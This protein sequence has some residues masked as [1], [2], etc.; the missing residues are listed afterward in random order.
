[1]IIANLLR[2]DHPSGVVR[3]STLPF[4][5]TDPEG[6]T[7]IGGG[8]ILAL[9]PRGASDAQDGGSVSITWNGASAA[10][11]AEAFHPALIRSRLWIAAVW[12]NEGSPPTRAHG[13]V[14]AWTG[15]VETPQIGG[16][17]S[18]PSISITAQSYLLDMARPKRAL[19]T[20]VSQK[21]ID[22]DDTGADWIAQL[23]DYSPKLSARQ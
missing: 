1:M 5:W 10:L 14:N 3:M 17:P 4:D 9:S 19:L 11:I 6:A 20:P 13:P 12:L 22:P 18:N 8:G 23:A 7:W 21:A 15:L 16:D 2:L